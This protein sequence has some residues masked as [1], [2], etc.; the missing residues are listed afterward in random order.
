MVGVQRPSDQ[1]A[2]DAYF[3]AFLSGDVLYW[4]VRQEIVPGLILPLT[5][6]DKSVQL[7]VAGG[8]SVN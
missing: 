2:T 6:L 8:P 7:W 4:G 3:R 5:F 1:E